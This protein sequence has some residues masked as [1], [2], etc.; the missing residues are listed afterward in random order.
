MTHFLQLD[1]T[2]QSFLLRLKVTPPGGDQACDTGVCGEHFTLVTVFP[3]M[4]QPHHAGVSLLLKSRLQAPS[5][6]SIEQL[7]KIHL[8]SFP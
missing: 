5:C 8:N 4:D 6:S 3:K 7:G 1:F 2:I